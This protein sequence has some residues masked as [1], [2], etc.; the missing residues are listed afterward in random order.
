MAGYKNPVIKIPFPEDLSDDC[1]VVIRNPRLIPAREMQSFYEGGREIAEAVQRAAEE[2]I[3]VP[4]DLV[5]EENTAG[6]YKLAARLIV[7]WRVWDPRV[8]VQV[9]DDG[10]LIENEETKPRL[11]PPPPVTPELAGL[12][13]QEVLTAVLQEISKV[14]PQ[15]ATASQGDGTS[16]TS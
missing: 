5:T 13:P 10:N 1:H 7:G 8:P 3:E 16:K 14:N 15:N 6:M 12:L 9:D 2:G 11:L 4:D